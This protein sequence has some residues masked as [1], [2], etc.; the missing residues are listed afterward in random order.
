MAIPRYYYTI[1][2]AIAF[3]G[4]PGSLAL[5]YYLISGDPSFQPLAQSVERQALAGI[6]NPSPEGLA[7]HVILR[8]SGRPDQE[9]QINQISA[10]IVRAL[11]AKGAD[12][13]VDLEPGVSGAPSVIYFVAHSTIGPM[14]ITRAAD[15]VDAAAQA[16]ALLRNANGAAGSE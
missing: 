9:A 5:T 14:P 11:D 16:V 10:D 6:V 12:A 8:W 2:A 15:G 3:V 7:V 13:H 1:A 4:A